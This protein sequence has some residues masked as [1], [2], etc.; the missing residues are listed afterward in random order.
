MPQC[1][2]ESFLVFIRDRNNRN[3]VWNNQER[4]LVL[5]A[6]ARR[7]VDEQRD[8]HR[9]F[10]FAY[11]GQPTQSV[12]S[13]GWNLAPNRAGVPQVS[14]HGLRHTFGHRLRAAPPHGPVNFSHASHTTFA[15]KGQ[16]PKGVLLTC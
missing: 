15:R 10:V 3:R 13:S 7:V 5:N 4:V 9:D 11:R 8:K 12:L 1:V 16:W 6:I 2:Q 14:V